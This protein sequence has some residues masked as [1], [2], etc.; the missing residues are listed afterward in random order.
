ML[1]KRKLISNS[2]AMLVNR[3]A[4]S[5]ATFVLSAA[6]ARFLGAYELGQYLLAFSYYFI[7][8]TLA[9]QGLKTLFTRELARDPEEA[10][11]YLVSGTC[12]QLLFSLV[13]YLAL[14]VV[15]LI[16]PYHH[17]TSMVCYLMGL[18]IVPFALSNITEAIFQAQEKMHLIAATT[19]PIYI[20]RLILMLEAMHL[21]YGI[22]AVAV[23]FVVSEVLIFLL[24]WVI[25]IRFVKPEWGIQRDFI[26]Q[27]LREARTFF[28]I[29]GITVIGSRMEVVILSVLGSE[30]LL[31]FYGAVVQLLQPFLIIANSVAIA[32]FPA[33]S[34][35]VNQGKREQQK[36]TENLIEILMLIALP[37]LV[38]IL[39]TSEELLTLVYG[40]SFA[41]AGLALK[42]SAFALI[43]LPF[44]R[45]LSFL[46][47]ANGF[48]RVNL[49]E[50]MVTTPIGGFIGIVLISQFQLLGAA[51]MDLVTTVI[52][53]SQYIFASYRRLFAL[54][55]WRIFARP[56]LVSGL[57][58][59]LFVILNR[60][61]LD[62]WVVLVIATTMYGVLVGLLGMFA[63][64]GARLVYDKLWNR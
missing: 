58:V 53:S 32:I 29:E 46:L 54:N 2:L 22:A 24:Q 51:A 44:N 21:K 57:M 45:A 16:M 11:T 12:L 1:E 14:V 50:V 9:S 61:P 34:R 48:E 56:L 49:R 39:F 38:G 42:I 59:P 28:A 15:V 4:Q 6:I 30:A 27:T 64:G 43:L 31:G 13:A 17:D 8:V 7:F 20:L 18:A 40:S 10:S 5:I 25:I 63:M 3:L 19:V 33:M 36:I 23:I 52:A 60:S 55:L 62:F 35:T 47:V 37:F 41:Q 26:R